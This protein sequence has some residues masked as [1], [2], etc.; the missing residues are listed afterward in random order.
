LNRELTHFLSPNRGDHAGGHPDHELRCQEPAE[1]CRRITDGQR[2]GEAPRRLNRFWLL[3]LRWCEPAHDNRQETSHGL[4]D[5]RHQTNQDGGSQNHLT[6]LL[7]GL[8][9]ERSPDQGKEYYHQDLGEDH[10]PAGIL[11][12]HWI[13]VR[14]ARDEGLM[15]RQPGTFHQMQQADHH[16]DHR[17]SITEAAHGPGAWQVLIV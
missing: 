15:W 5:D 2:N 10:L 8:G 7:L 13:S 12:G 11:T 6:T 17:E 1:E 4:V 9:Q 16:A 3:G 14:G